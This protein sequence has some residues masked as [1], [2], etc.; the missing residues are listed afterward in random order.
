MNG[1]RG[2]IPGPRGRVV[3]VTADGLLLLDRGRLRD[4]PLGGLGFQRDAALADVRVGDLVWVRDGRV[5]LVH[6]PG[7][8]EWPPSAQTPGSRLAKLGPERWRRLEQRAEIARRVRRWFDDR[9]FLEVETPLVVPSPGTELH[10]DPV[11]VDLSEA[12][13]RTPERRWLITSPEYAMKELLA[14]G[15]PPIYQLCRV[16]RDGERGGH[17]RPEF[18]MLE[19]YRPWVDGYGVIME[20]CESLLTTLAGERLRWRGQDFDLRPPW[21][22]L[23]FFD[24]LRERADIR[25]PEG[26][27]PDRWIE[28]LVDRVEPTLGL[29]GPELVI[30]WP[31]ELAS[32]SRQHPKNPLVSERFEL[33]L[34]RLEL[35]NAFGELTD[36]GE[37]RRRCELDNLERRRVGKPELPLDD[38]F[39]GAL[40]VGMPPSAGIALGFDRLVMVLTDAA[41]IDEVLAF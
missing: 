30:E 40:T 11:A 7:R 39:L 12:P 18:T 41:S 36:A 13:G 1:D 31:V 22:R 4:L 24:L 15:A 37:Q 14:A 17:H 8:P 16:F 23:R 20:D 32:L 19:W 21:P 29:T 5:E 26:L 9:G 2:E 28:A 35:A 25:E 34:G 10:L 38:H 33:Y 6:R 3:A 27:G